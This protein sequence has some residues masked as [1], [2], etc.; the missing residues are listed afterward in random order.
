MYLMEDGNTAV[1]GNADPSDKAAQWRVVF[2]GATKLSALKNEGSGRYLVIN[3][4]AAS[5]RD[6][7]MFT[8]SQDA[9]VIYCWKLLRNA[10]DLYP[11]AVRFQ[12][13]K[14]SSSY[15]H[16]E[17]RNNVAEFSSAVQPEWGTPHWAPVDATN[18]GSLGSIGTPV[19]PP[20][21]YVRL[22]NENRSDRESNYLYETIAGG[23]YYGNYKEKDA[24]SHWRFTDAGGGM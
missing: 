3:D 24:R 13:A 10:N 19:T 20:G 22:K 2:D 6:A 21:G 9:G 5:D 7:L 8:G 23:M 1:Y 16:T 11:T 18:A 14:T 12:G 15:L 4:A 17:S